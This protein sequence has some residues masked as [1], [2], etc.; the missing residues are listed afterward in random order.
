M[1]TTAKSSI[2]ENVGVSKGMR[3]EGLTE[4]RKR[5]RERAERTSVVYL[6]PPFSVGSSHQRGKITHGRREE[7]RIQH[8]THTHI[9]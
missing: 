2:L 1:G 9:A 5:E 3:E 7:K 4:Y 6:P 8:S